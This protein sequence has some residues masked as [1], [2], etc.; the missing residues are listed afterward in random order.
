MKKRLMDI[1]DLL[2][3]TVSEWNTDQAPR[4]AAAL[5]Y[6]TAF[7][8]APLLVVVIAI[9][10]LI[11]SQDRVE[12]EVVATIH[13]SAGLDA[14]NMVRD[15][16]KNAS[17]P[18]E[19]AI[20]TTL[21]IVTL[22]LGAGGAFMQLQTAL[23]II[24][25]VK[26]PEQSTSQGIISTIR[27]NLL[28]FG[29]VLMIGFLLLVSLVISTMLTALGTFVT[30]FLPESEF[31][32]QIINFAISFG[33]ITLLFAL[34]FKFLP[35]TTVD[36]RDVWVGAAFTALLFS[37]GKFVLGLYLGR[38]SVTSAYGAAGSL[39]VILLWVYYSAQIMLFGAEFTQVYA[40]RRAEAANP[41]AQP[42]VLL[43][44]GSGAAAVTAPAK[45]V[46]AETP[47]TGEVLPPETAPEQ[48]RKSG[49]IASIVFMIGTFIAGLIASRLDTRRDES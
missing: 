40:K 16:I 27:D 45:V 38:A 32:V 28:S 26:R 34:M 20:S 12:A 43:P 49:L 10:G 11:V 6:Y 48:P 15:L 46:A 23:D 31:L 7:S 36:W 22:L 44:D 13:K 42:V 37:I 2:R 4:L 18:G 30:G 39:V 19:G 47:K 21:S 9:V 1:F 35:H 17:N 33:I 41:L 24:W 8:L 25:N 14:A 3:Q 29:M 5:A